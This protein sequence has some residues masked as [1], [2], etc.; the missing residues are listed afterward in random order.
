MF[1]FEGL[2]TGVIQEPT[3]ILFFGLFFLFILVAYKVVKMLIRALVIAVLSGLFP[4]IGNLFFGMNIPVTIDNIIWFAMTGVEI[5]FVY[6]IIVDIG[7]LAEIFMKPFR[8]GKVKKVEKVIIMERDKH[9][10]KD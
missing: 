10:K 6:H 2:L 8:R 5:Y 7:K 9:E 4:V 3:L 1:G